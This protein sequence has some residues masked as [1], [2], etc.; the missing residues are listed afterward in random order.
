MLINKENM[1]KNNKN[2]SDT[3]Q[4]SDV[5]TSQ[6]GSS[7]FWSRFS[8]N[9]K[10]LSAVIIIILAGVGTRFIFFSHAASPSVT[11]VW[12]T[13]ADWNSGTLSNA[14]VGNNDVMLAS[15][16]NG[17]APT[18]QS[19]TNLALNRPA[20]SS[21][22]QANYYGANKAFDG[23]FHSRWSS[24]FSDPQWLYVDLGATYNINSVKIY[25]E[26]ACAK[27]YQIQV[28]SNAS[29]WTSIYSTTA[30]TGGTSTLS[31][32]SGTGRYVRMY[33]TARC[34]Q[35]GYSIYEMQVFGAPVSSVSYASSGN[36]VL[37]YN[38]STSVNWTSL[39]ATD[40][41]PTNTNIT[42]QA[43]SSTD[44]STWSSWSS[45]VSSLPAG[46][47]LQIEALLSTSNNT[48]TPLL[49]SLILVYSP[50]VLTPTATLS[51]SPTTITA[52][53]SATL[54]WSSTNTTSCTASGA[55]SGTLATSGSQSTGALNST[56]SYGISC[57]GTGGT[58]TATTV[59][60]TVV[61]P[62]TT[63][64]NSASQLSSVLGVYP[65]PGAASSVATV[66]S[67]VGYKVHYGMD[68]FD[69]TSWST[70]DDPSWILGQWQ[71]SGYKM[72]WGVPML[73]TGY[74][75]TAGVAADGT[76]LATG[77][78]GAYDQYFKTLA[79]N[80]V[81]AGQGS[82]IIRL[83]WEFNG[84]WFPWAANGKAA[85][86]IGYWQQIVT[87]MR[88]VPGGNFSFM[89]NPDRSDLG[90]G[91]LAQYYP[92]DAYVDIVAL[93]VYDEEWASYPG[94][95]AEWNN[96]LTQA[97]GLDW[98]ASFGATHNKPLAIPEWGLGWTSNG[99][100]VAVT[101]PTTSSRWR[102][103]RPPTTC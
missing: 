34:T 97:D 33:G 25:W 88:S 78:T 6:H 3:G 96:M 65:G 71:G 64:P 77:A 41:L 61:P 16:T 93:D 31:N 12:S 49:N 98:L 9:N 23:N 69:A 59:T 29:N 75:S 8:R 66:N 92:G 43:R 84:D 42:V 76:S 103:G 57:S 91:D 99:E 28:S 35:W 5:V 11:K 53:Q 51:V 80:L 74:S 45:S 100:A 50:I 4:G 17:S 90:V 18:N 52:G 101:T 60:V 83:G 20:Y 82:S 48:I 24:Q 7:M 85:A 40:S 79:T 27:A 36:I 89:W 94:A 47:Y 46:Q 30:G 72:I 19:T 21:S 67:L 56:S 22:N 87:S 32:L 58:A 55:W 70:I 26:R 2:L 44:N 10:I 95:A 38:A 54:T 39:T 37:D 68:F 81:A 62:A 15:I 13:T 73:P 14:T 86:F 102:A 63:P 1:F